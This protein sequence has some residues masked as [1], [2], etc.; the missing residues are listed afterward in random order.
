MVSI[1]NWGF[2]EDYFLLPGFVEDY[3]QHT[4][5]QLDSNNLRNPEGFRD[6]LRRLGENDG[7]MIYRRVKSI[8]KSFEGIRNSFCKRIGYLQHEGGPKN[9][10]DL[11]ETKVCLEVDLGE[12]NE[13]G[14]KNSMLVFYKAD[15]TIEGPLQDRREGRRSR[16][17]SR[18]RSRRRR[19]SRSRSRRRVRSRSRSRGRRRDARKSVCLVN[20]VISK[21]ENAVFNAEIWF[22]QAETLEESQIIVQI[23]ECRNAVCSELKSTKK[24]EHYKVRI[25]AKVKNAQILVSENAWEKVYRE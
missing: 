16:S 24:N 25:C 22:C 8:T 10:V 6:L 3:F 21:N 20:H 15:I 13:E 4:Q 14:K 17:R 11:E 9:G 23:E 12:R 19:R 5:L 18:S 1:K 7:G 2:V